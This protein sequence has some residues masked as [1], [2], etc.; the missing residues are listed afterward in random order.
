[1]PPGRPCFFPSGFPVS[2]VPFSGLYG[3]LVPPG[4]VNGC[5]GRKKRSQ[6]PFF[7]PLFYTAPSLQYSFPPALIRF[8]VFFHP[9]RDPAFPLCIYPVSLTACMVQNPMPPAVFGMVDHLFR[10]HSGC[11]SS[12]FSSCFFVIRVAPP[13]CRMNPH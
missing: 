7:P 3:S 4:R 11:L 13:L 12:S 6:H 10:S 1:V 8:V 2:L 5:Y 9:V